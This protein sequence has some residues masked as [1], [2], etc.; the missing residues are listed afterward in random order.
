MVFFKKMRYLY[1]FLYFTVPYA[2]H[3]FFRRIRTL[4]APQERLGRT[5]Y[6]V[7]HPSSFMDPMLPSSLSKP[8][9]LFMTRAD[10]YKGF[11]KH[12]FHNGHMLPVFRQ[13]DGDGQNEKNEEIFKIVAKEVAG[14]KNVLVFAEGF[15]D[16]VFVRSLKPIKKGILR[17]A[18]QSLEAMNWRED[19]YVQTMGINYTHPKHFRSEVL[20]S[21]GKK[22][23][24]NDYKEAY[25]ANPKKLMQ[26]LILSIENDI[27][28]EITYIEDR[29]RCDFHENVMRLTRKGM[30]H[31]NTDFSFPLEQR[32]RYSQNLANWL[33]AQEQDTIAPLDADM[34]DYF[35]AMSA[36]PI[37]ENDVVEY[38]QNGKLNNTSAWLFNIFMA[39]MALLGL[40]FGWIS[41][42][43]IKPKIE[44]TFKR[45]VFWSSAKLFTSYLVGMI[46]FLVLIALFYFVVYPSILL[47]LLLIVLTSGPAFIVF[48]HWI[49]NWKT[50]KR[51][52]KIATTDLKSFAEK[53]ATLIKQIKK[54]VQVA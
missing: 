16:D 36:T 15:T 54:V 32:W 9:V 4:N 42:F 41:W 29:E 45:D 10:I 43:I 26:E 25:L 39:P 2:L 1:F 27:K 20:M 18:F 51:R 14:G 50:I 13:Q 22:I 49:K 34:K 30:N 3:T 19:V 33:N 17:M 11:L 35:S 53:R 40:F 31:E 5:F 46:Y 44:K 52:K 28:A 7:N 38:I 8:I 21:Y 6:A 48:Y 23:R 37:R 47:W 24:V 12:L